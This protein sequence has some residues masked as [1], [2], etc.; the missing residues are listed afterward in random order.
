MKP[1]TS[2]RR[3]LTAPIIGALLLFFI[4]DAASL[5]RNTLASVHTAYDR[6]LLASAKAIGETVSFGNG[7][8]TV[9][10]PYAALEVFEADTRSR[11]VYR[12]N[13]FD[14]NFVS[15]YASLPPHQGRVPQTTAYS[16]LVEFYEDV[17]EGETVR[18]AALLQPVFTSSG[19][20]MVTVQ[21]AETLE[22]R[23][24]LAQQALLNSSIRQA[25][26][27]LVLS[28]VIWWLISDGLK[29]ISQLRQALLERSPDALSPF[30]TRTSRELLPVVEALNELMERLRRVLDNQQRFVRDA[31]HQLRTPLAVLKVQVQNAREGHGS[32]AA[33]LAELDQSVDRA[34]RVANQM[35]S[36]AKVAQ[37]DEQGVDSQ[38]PVNLIEIAREI[39]VECSPLISQKRLDFAL[40]TQGENLDILGIHDWMIRELLRNLLGNAI[41]YTP[42]NGSLGIAIEAQASMIEMTVWDSGNGIT[43]QQFSQLFQPFST[44]DPVHGSGLGLLICR[45]ICRAMNAELKLHNRKAVNWFDPREVSASGL[46]AVVRLPR[47]LPIEVAQ[48]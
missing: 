36:L 31:S 44:G 8:L 6:T 25:L 34:T 19:Y 7:K 27:T 1:T 29:P 41:H 23:R 14:G 11:M 47:T 12:V 42:I 39:A 26:L 33:A 35:L 40:D 20:K 18:V 24:S 28:C 13:D 22:L 45:D 4:V 30:N 10:L 43:D 2:I 48:A 46:L 3:R 16:A 21:V 38:S 37:L 5:Y 15:G 17:Y 9:L 32:P